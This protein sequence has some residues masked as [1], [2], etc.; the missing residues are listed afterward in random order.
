VVSVLLGQASQLAPTCRGRAAAASSYR[1]GR[2]SLIAAGE[3][4][5]DDPGKIADGTAMSCCAWGRRF[6]KGRLKGMTSHWTAA[7]PPIM[8]VCLT[9][10]LVVACNG[11]D[12]AR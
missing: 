7:M 8:T 3:V 5:A 9:A 6:P 2:D 4:A 12:V 11:R 10:S 1:A